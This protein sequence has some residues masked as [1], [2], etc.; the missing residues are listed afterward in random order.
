MLDVGM[1]IEAQGDA[2]V[3]GAPHAIFLLNDVVE[4]NLDSTRLVT[5]AAAS[6]SFD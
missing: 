5:N 4:F 2:V 1:A 6:L 3:D